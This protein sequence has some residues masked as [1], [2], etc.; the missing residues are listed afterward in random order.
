MMLQV[1]KSLPLKVVKGC[2]KDIHKFS[3]LIEMIPWPGSQLY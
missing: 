3:I 1:G 2:H